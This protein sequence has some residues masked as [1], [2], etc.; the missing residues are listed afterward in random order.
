[1]LI[2]N[3]FYCLAKLSKQPFIYFISDKE[4]HILV[5]LH[6]TTWLAILEQ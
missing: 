6:Q 2:K 1:M 3:S 4:T 5:F